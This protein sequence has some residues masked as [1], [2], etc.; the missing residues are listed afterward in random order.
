[1]KVLFLLVLTILLS[2][3]DPYGFG[4][5]KNPAYVLDRAF[6]SILALDY[7]SFIK[8]SGKEALCLY[9]N[10]EGLGYLR[11]KISLKPSQIDIKPKLV[12]NASTYTNAPLYVGYWS[13]YNEKFHIDILDK[14]TKRDLIKVLVECHY[15]FE[16][17]K[18]DSYKQLNLKKYRKKECRLI[19][20]IP[21]EFSPLSM[22]SRCEMLKVSL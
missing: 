21:V 15:G 14:N 22:T 20:I 5:K 7:E 13:Y 16:G 10:L 6:D 2:S 3:C 9:G 17:E 18:S 4:F 1:M 12:E 19:Q 11:D 8:V